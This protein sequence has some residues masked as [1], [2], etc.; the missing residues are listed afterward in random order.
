MIHLSH[1]ERARRR[2]Y[3]GSNPE[4]GAGSCAVAVDNARLYR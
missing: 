3:Y 2:Q 4:H 1:Y